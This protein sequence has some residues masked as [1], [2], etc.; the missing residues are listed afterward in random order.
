MNILILTN[1]LP[2][3]PND[4]GA[5]AT[6]NMITGLQAAGNQV[7]CLAINT[8]KHPF[9]LEEIPPTLIAAVR[10][11]AVDG[12]TSI[13]P[14]PLL[15]NLFFTRRPYIAARFCLKEYM[16][17]LE[18]L[19]LE[20][21]FDL[22]QLEGPYMGHYIRQLRE[23]SNGRIS[24]RAHNVEH[25]IWLRKARNETHPGKR[26]YLRNMSA[27]LKRYELEV[28][29]ATDIL[30]PIS[31]VDEAYFKQ[32]GIKKPMLTIPAGL[33]LKQYPFSS[34]PAEPTLFFIGAL[35][36]IPN[37][38]GL[39][40]FLQTT[41]EPLVREVPSLRFHIA[42]RNAP[43]KLVRKLNHPQIVFHG[44][45][46]DAPAFMA[47]CRV[48]VAPLLTGSGIR[49]KILE[50]MAMGRPVA[51]TPIGIE[52]ID[53]KSG[54]EVVVE[55]EPARLASHLARLLT[56]D[57]VAV[58]MAR[59]ARQFVADN[60]DTFELSTRLSQFYKSQV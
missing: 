29:N 23:Q 51:T 53:A 56:M 12:D 42:G 59:S 11:M 25:L 57:E 44:E 48:M 20:T 38:E 28:I 2:Y 26:W 3:P 55:K 24:L 46:A 9:P 5:I 31:S 14:L 33:S 41:F 39:L 58:P 10:F 49:V 18:Q 47:S 13:K 52:G 17:L 34:L 27:R 40:W 35:D 15:A 32:Q 19:L 1:K 16:A 54:I 37:Q 30:V 60:F 8:R 4:G 50:G 45:V 22:V 6:L 7:T 43:E 36:W 21:R